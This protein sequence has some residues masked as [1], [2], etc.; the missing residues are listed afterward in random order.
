MSGSGLF[1]IPGEAARVHGDGDVA[2]R[3]G[4]KQD[5]SEALQLPR[6]PANPEMI[7]IDT[8]A[9]RRFTVFRKLK[10]TYRAGFP[11]LQN[12]PSETVHLL[13]G[14]HT[15]FIVETFDSGT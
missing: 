10:M 15:S 5:A 12:P 13:S 7:F 9:F 11:I 4:V 1:V 6:R 8:I 2:R 3:A 14:Y